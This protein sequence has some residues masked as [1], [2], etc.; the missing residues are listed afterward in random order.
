M[1]CAVARRELVR[2]YRYKV[3]LF[4]S[5]SPRHQT[6]GK[7]WNLYPEFRFPLKRKSTLGH[8]TGL[9]MSKKRTFSSNSQCF[10][11]SLFS[12]LL[13]PCLFPCPDC[14]LLSS[15][16]NTQTQTP[17]CTLCFIRTCVFVS[18]FQHFAFLS[19][20]TTQ[21]KHLY[22]SGIR[23]RNPSQRSAADPRLKLPSQWDR[24]SMP[25]PA[26]EPIYF[27]SEEHWYHA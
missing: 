1:S 18:A 12:V 5:R 10:L 6:R 13:Y 16:Y 15:L 9:K 25:T 8:R 23:M 27:T 3:E 11:I 19:L 26:F 4:L 24:Q 22:L 2:K 7:M 17:T 21:H 14:C 20:L